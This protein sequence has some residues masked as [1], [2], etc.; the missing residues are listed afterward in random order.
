MSS[1]S[2]RIETAAPAG[3]NSRFYVEWNLVSQ[4]IANN[5]STISWRAGL[6]IA[7]WD[8]WYLNAV[9]IDGGNVHNQGIPGGAWSNIFGTTQLRSG[10]VTVQHNADGTGAF[11]AH[12]N[13][14]LYSYGNRSVSGS[15]NLPTI[16][17]A[18]TPSMAQTI[19]I[20]TNTTISLPRASGSFTHRVTYSFNGASGV[21]AENAGS[22]VVWAIP[23]SIATRRPNHTSGTGTITVQTKS[24]GHVIG[25]KSRGFTANIPNTPTFKPT[26]TDYSITEANPEVADHFSF[27]I[28][29][30]S[31]LALS[32]TAQGAY[33][34]TLAFTTFLFEDWL[35]DG[36]QSTATSPLLPIG[37]LR[38]VGFI[39]ID[40]RARS[41]DGLTYEMIEVEE[42]VDP[43][44]TMAFS[45]A[46]SA[47]AWDE[48]GDHVV[49][50]PGGLIAPLRN[51]NTASFKLKYKKRSATTWTEIPIT[52][53]G[54]GPFGEYAL[55]LNDDVMLIPGIDVDS[56]YDFVLEATD[57]FSTTQ[58][59]I[60]VPTAFTMMDFH[61]SGRAVSFGRVS[62]N[63]DRFEI[64]PK[65]PFN[66]I[67]ATSNEE[68]K[69]L[70]TFRR[71]DD[72]LLA[73]LSTGPDGIG[74]KADQFDAS[75]E[76]NGDF[77][78]L[79]AHPVGS[80]YWNETDSRNP[81]TVYGGT[82]VALKGVVLGGKSDVSGSPF[83]VAAG[84]IIGA[85]THT[86][87]EEQLAPH[88]HTQYGTSAPRGSGAGRLVLQT[89]GNMVY[90]RGNNSTWA[91]GGGGVAG[92][93]GEVTLSGS[94]SR[95]TSTNGGG[96]PH[97]NIQRT[98]V[99]YLWKR[100]A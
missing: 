100:I 99:G 60:A 25:T 74:V 26:I 9:R 57:F 64:G 2:G 66:V 33:G 70:I 42:Y 21:I 23:N 77:I 54:T 63:P 81:G 83:N 13:G 11:G 10:T 18:T 27:F 96:Q 67:A 49:I 28:Q 58:Y 35:S 73:K 8:L 84:T 32:M 46:D 29:N 37:G 51:E 68:N 71:A 92:G 50:Y 24:G 12:I 76:R 3:K 98:L 62:N 48:D 1:R 31:Q 19:T 41:Q 38:F 39:A 40:S 86:L 45:R 78:F 93:R 87:T 15:W 56:P 44:V 16:P 52:P 90:Y 36:Q 20:G 4:N 91:T 30:K 61:S 69:D 14:W 80:T 65:L 82:W 72:T 6:A 59:P 55:D 75:G 89:D 22:S 43:F 79:A 97:N 47:G 88:D 85:D 94:E 34:S 95:A 17:R 5:T 53:T 7:R